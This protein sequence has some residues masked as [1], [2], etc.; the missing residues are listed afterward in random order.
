MKHIALFALSAVLA[1]PLRAGEPVF[2]ADY[3]T[4][5]QKP[6]EI[7]I[8][9]PDGNYK[10]TLVLGDAKR[11]GIT[12]VKAESRRLCLYN[13]ATRKGE[14]KVISFVVNKRDTKIREGGETVGEV[15]IKPR[16]IGK[17]NWDG[18][19]TLEIGGAAPAVASIIVEPAGKITTVYLCGDSTVVDQDNEPY[20]SWGQMFPWFFDEH[21][22]IANYAESGERL[23]TFFAAG[24]LR[25][26][27][28][29]VQPGDYVFV[30]FGHN[31]MKLK[32]PGKGGHYFFAT[33]LKTYI[34]MIREKDAIPVLVTPTH[35]RNLDSLGRIIETHGDYPD[36]MRE[37]ARREQVA[38]IELHDLSGRFYEALGEPASKKALVHVPA[39]AYPWVDKAIAD[40]THFSPYGAF[41]LSKI[42]TGEIVRMHLPLE[43]HVRNFQGFDPAY[44]DN[45]DAFIWEQSP[46]RDLSAQKLE[47]DDDPTQ[48]R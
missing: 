2:K 1:L 8:P 5:G 46:Y 26:I 43:T 45:P 10:V 48:T 6:F 11:S 31:D 44:P 32:G 27:L 19:L 40:N 20:A 24:R 14:S 22:C 34:D 25:K 16:E 21:V 41:E 29:L 33:Q 12:T 42:V 36:G 47:K 4:K 15:S 3:T 35:R 39:G 9:V 38:L 28:S 18:D 37:V 23:D 17:L 30:E 13:E 7:T